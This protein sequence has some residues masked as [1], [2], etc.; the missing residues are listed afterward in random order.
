MIGFNNIFLKKNNLASKTNQQL[1]LI[2]S[3]N[4]HYQID[5]QF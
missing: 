5:N 1:Q 3:A 4:R 2:A